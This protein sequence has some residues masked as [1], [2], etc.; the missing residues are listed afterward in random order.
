VPAPRAQDADG[1]AAP[2]RAAERPQRQQVNASDA[3]ARETAPATSS[4]AA[5]QPPTVLS[6]PDMTAATPTIARQAAEEVA[7]AAAAYSFPLAIALMVAVFLAVQGRID[8]RDP[9]LA[10]GD[11]DLELPFR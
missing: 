10:Y 9:K 1:G 2:H 3:T 8:A 6:A 11:D 4:D 7:R 5:V